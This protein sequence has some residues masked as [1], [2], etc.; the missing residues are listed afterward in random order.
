MS[1][2]KIIDTFLTKRHKYLTECATNILKYNPIVEPN[3]L[4]GELA[5]YL[6][7]NKT[8]IEEYL[9]IEKLEAFCVSWMKHTM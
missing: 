8:K 7:N 5:L 9:A 4:V 6:Y 3:E 2:K 1:Y